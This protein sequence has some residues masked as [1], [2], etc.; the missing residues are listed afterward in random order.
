[1]T[2]RQEALG[3]DVVQHGEEAYN[4]GEGAILLTPEAG[5][6]AEFAVPEPVAQ[7]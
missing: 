4:S 5:M 7:P 6:E 3:M 2:E 1:V